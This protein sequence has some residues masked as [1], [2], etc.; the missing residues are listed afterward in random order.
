[1]KFIEEFKLRSSVL[2]DQVYIYFNLVW[3]KISADVKDLITKM[4][5]DPAHRLTAEQVLNH[6]WVLNNAPNSSE[7][8]LNL[9]VENLKNYRNI[10]KLKKA[11]LVFIA[12]R[13]NE[14]DIKNLKETFNSI[15]KNQDG[16]LTLEEIKSGVSQL[17]NNS[18]LNIEE[19]FKSID[20]D[21]SGVINYTEFLAA[22]IDQNVYLKEERLYEA[23]KMFDKDDS[24]KI[25]ID[26]VKQIM[27]EDDDA[28]IQ[29]IIKKY[30]L[31]NDG[32]IDYAEFLNMMTKIDIN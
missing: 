28:K 24:G 26:E 9:N 20:T 21:G 32:E 25:S 22:S 7:S 5:A 13:L 23:F 12:S 3:D 10:N 2:L 16:T 31:N 4:L 15:D 30:D 27:K 6:T 11:V 17:K 18:N 19:I 14:S 29:E 1:M 8:I